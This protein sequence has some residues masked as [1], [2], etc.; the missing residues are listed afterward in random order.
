VPAWV[1]QRGGTA[2]GWVEP[3]RSLAAMRPMTF[4]YG[5]TGHLYYPGNTSAGT[6][7]PAVIWLHGYSYPLGYMW[8]YRTDTHP[9]LALVNAGYAVLA[10][11][12]VG[13]GSRMSDFAPFYKRHPHW[14][15]MGRMVEDTTRA[16]DVLSAD[17]AIDPDRIAVFGYTIGGTVGLYA[18][19]LD[20]RIRSVVSI[21][22]FTPMRT[23]TADRGTGGLARYSEERALLPRLGF[24]VGHEG[25]LP[26]DFDDVLAAIAPRSVLVVEPTMD[27][28]T[29]PGD[30]RQ[31]VIRARR[32][33]E[34]YSAADKLAIHEPVDYTRLTNATQD[35]AVRWMNQ[36]HAPSPVAVTAA[37]GQ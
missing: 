31:A 37:P 32:V 27:R 9:I 12:Q 10:F 34:L 29:T 25:R 15:L 3:G 36:I 11:D 26:Y 23:D 30:V 2:F 17:A 33:Y 5:V 8:V 1:I 4:G 13:F 28:A 6:R 14:S 22:G 19:A 16:V 21:S 20:P 35:W 7:L 24:F 18:A